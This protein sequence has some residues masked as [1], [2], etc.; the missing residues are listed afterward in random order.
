VPRT[1]LHV[2]ENLEGGLGRAIADIAAEAARRGDDVVLASDPGGPVADRVAAGGVAVV[3]WRA[4]PRPGPA[5]LRE[6]A[7]LARIVARVAPDVVHLHSSKAGMAGRL[8]VRGARPTVFQPHAW[9]FLAR[10]GAVAPLARGW[11]RAGARWVHAVVCVSEDERRIGERAGIHARF[12]VVANGVDVEAL[13]PAGPQERAGALARL[14]LGPAPLAVCVGRL[15]RQKNQA[16]LLDV[17]PRVRA[18]VPGARLALVG[19][20]EDG[21]ELAARAV[22]GVLLAGARDDVPDWLAAATVVVQPSRWEGMSLSVLEAL[23]RARAVVATDVP[24]MAEAIGP[25]G[26]V[27]A[28]GDAGA[29]AAAVTARLADPSRA[30]AEGAAGRERVERDHDRRRQLARLLAVYDEV[31]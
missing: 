11:E 14:G 10:G 2:S 30:D 1:I 7:A 24:G 6:T 21:P 4:G 20:G 8:A 5:V 15:H 23:A 13:R 17:W 31:A 12:V 9:S 29:L 3:P 16:A 27:V 25:A 26:A 22:E 18:A 19:D 28:L